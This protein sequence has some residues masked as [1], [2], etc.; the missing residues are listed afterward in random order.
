LVTLFGLQKHEQ[1]QEEISAAVKQSNL[2]TDEAFFAMHFVDE[3]EWEGV[4]CIDGMVRKIRWNDKRLLGTIA[5]EIGLLKG[6]RKLDF[7]TNQIQ[8]SIPEEMYDLAELKELH[9]YMNR[10]TGTL[11]SRMG[12]WWNMTHLHLSHNQFTGSLPASFQSADTIRPIRKWH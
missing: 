8:G 5:A 9:L 10:L 7:S 11:S 2:F 12:N 1:N 4:K 3:C 6:L